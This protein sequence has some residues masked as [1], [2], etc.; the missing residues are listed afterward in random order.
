MPNIGI[1]DLDYTFVDENGEF[2]P[3]TL[4]WLTQLDSFVI[5]THRSV[6]HAK[7]NIQKHYPTVN[8]HKV[9]TWRIIGRYNELRKED[10][11]LPELLFVSTLDDA[12]YE[13]EPGQGYQT[14]LK[15]YELESIA[16]NLTRHSYQSFVWPNTDSF[17]QHNQQS[18][19]RHR[20]STTDEDEEVQRFIT[21]QHTKNLQFEPTAHKLRK[22]KRFITLKLHLLDDNITMLRPFLP[23]PTS[24]L[25][26]SPSRKQHTRFDFNKLPYKTELSV[27]HIFKTQDGAHTI[28]SNRSYA[29][30]SQLCTLLN[31]FIYS[32]Q[33][34]SSLWQLSIELVALRGIIV[35]SLNNAEE[36]FQETTEELEETIFNELLTRIGQSTVDIDLSH[37]SPLDKTLE[38]IASMKGFEMPN[39]IIQQ[40][41]QALLPQAN[42]SGHALNPS[43]A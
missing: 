1:V 33:P 16:N 17:Y 42:D 43:V 37:Y 20:T 21:M 14:L 27:N 22:H 11:Q 2:I 9:L 10:P 6:M 15:P 36:S 32:S 24:K 40:A 30:Q 41:K 29:D 8:P 34:G 35:L 7:P 5:W 39:D 3:E 38:A 28:I 25:N 26:D 23:S 19:M 31:D 13:L 4:Q 18:P 12:I